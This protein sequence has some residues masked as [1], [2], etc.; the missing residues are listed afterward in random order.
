[1]KSIKTREGN[2]KM[3]KKDKEITHM[4]QEYHKIKELLP[5]D[6]LLFVKRGDFYEL[7]FDD[8]IKCATALGIALRRIRGEEGEEETLMCRLPCHSYEVDTSHLAQRGLR[9]IIF[10]PEGEASLNSKKR[11]KSDVKA[12]GFCVSSSEK[13]RP[14]S[15]FLQR[16]LGDLYKW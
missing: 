6:C 9:N 16:L 12:S 10:D 7:Y 11:E 8:A 14:K 13:M 2:N 3:A 5:P 1:M 4:M 15:F